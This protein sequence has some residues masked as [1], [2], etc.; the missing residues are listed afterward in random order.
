MDVGD[1]VIGNGRASKEGGRA[2]VMLML[3]RV[4]PVGRNVLERG[5]RSTPG[6]LQKS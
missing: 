1:A 3:E 5:G 4:L 6:E 2:P